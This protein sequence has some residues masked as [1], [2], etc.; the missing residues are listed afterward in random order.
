MVGDTVLDVP[1]QTGQA[2]QVKRVVLAAALASLPALTGCSRDGSPEAV[3]DAFVDA[4]FVQVNQDKAKE[5]T[6]LGATKMLEDELREVAAVRKDG[7][8]PTDS[9]GDVFVRRGEASQRDQRIRF[10][11]VISVRSEA[12]ETVRSADVE[13]TQIQGGWKV[14]RVGVAGAA[15]T[16]PAVP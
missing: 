4:Y 13:L 8:D 5:F 15:N 10:P 12:G 1:V 16:D 14:V 11:Y 2:R 9:R 3:A 6:A 7:Y